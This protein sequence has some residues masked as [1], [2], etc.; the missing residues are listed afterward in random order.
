[1]WKNGKIQNMREVGK[2]VIFCIKKRSRFSKVT[3][4]ASTGTIGANIVS[5]LNQIIIENEYKIPHNLP[6]LNRRD[7]N[8]FMPFIHN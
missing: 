1:M 4:N 2:N 7:I 5:I 3:S 6:E 8:D